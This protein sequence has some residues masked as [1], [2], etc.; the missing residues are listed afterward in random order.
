[1]RDVAKNGQDKEQKLPKSALNPP[2]KKKCGNCIQHRNV[3]TESDEVN[4]EKQDVTKQT[5]KRQKMAHKIW[6]VFVQLPL[7]L[8]IHTH[9]QLVTFSPIYT[10]QMGGLI[11][12]GGWIICHK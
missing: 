2:Q 11:V 4:N 1:V 6:N 7:G 8:N 12:T 9:R 5:K 3:P 10:K